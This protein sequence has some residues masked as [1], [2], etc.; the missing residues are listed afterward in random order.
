MKY[1][2]QAIR[3]MKRKTP[4][5]FPAK[6][7]WNDA[8]LQ[9]PRTFPSA[10]FTR[11]IFLFI[12]AGLHRIDNNLLNSKLVLSCIG[13]SDSE[14]RRIFLLFRDPH[15]LQTFATLCTNSKLKQYLTKRF[16]NSSGIVSRS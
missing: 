10:D 2:L 8:W 6:S 9:I 1:F 14:R 11:F 3:R 16:G 4:Q 15:D 7:L 5:R 13:A 12:F